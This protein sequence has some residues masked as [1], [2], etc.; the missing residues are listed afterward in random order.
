MNSIEEII[1]SGLLE[2]YVVGDLSDQEST[3][4]EAKL[5]EF[6]VLKKELLAIEESL[7]QY[8]FANAVDPDPTLKGM[9]IAV[10]NYTSRLE[11]GETPVNPPSLNEDSKISDFK[12]WLDRSDLQEPDEY[13]A[14]Y[15]R[16]IGSNEEK[17][18][19]IVWLKEGAPDE[20]HTDELEKFLIVEGTCDITIGNTVHSLKAGDYLAIP[21]HINHNVR[22]TST[23]RCKVILERAAA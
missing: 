11:N 17:T 18:T 4:I 22:V 13:D 14:M 20:T 8:A 10:A 5:L 2:L 21:L 9:T 23:T 15:G 7:E 16:I 12:E 1:E 3:M 6:P 19:L